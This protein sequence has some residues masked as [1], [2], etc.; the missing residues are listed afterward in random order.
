MT[1]ASTLSHQAQP[2]MAVHA[3]SDTL[4]LQHYHPHNVDR[5]ERRL[6]EYVSYRQ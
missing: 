3:T 2:I 5:R 6:S 1:V 4:N